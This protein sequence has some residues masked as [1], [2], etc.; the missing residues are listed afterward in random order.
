MKSTSQKLFTGKRF[1][2]C[3]PIMEAINGS[4]VVT[5]EL[6]EYLQSNGADIRVYSCTFGDPVK[7]YCKKKN[8]KVDV[9]A[10]NPK[11]RLTDFDYIWSHSQILPISIIEELGKNLPKKMPKFIFL[12]M[13]GVDWI[14]DE[15]P[16]I[17]NLEK[18]L[19][20]KTLYISE[21]V[22]KTN[23]GFGLENLDSDFFRNPAPSKFKKRNRLPANKPKKILIVSNHPPEEV[24]IARDI[25]KDKHGFEVLTLGESMDD[26]SIVDIDLL[27]KFDA[28]ITIGKTAQYCLT[29][30]TPV[31]IYDWFGGPGWLN[32]DNY[33]RS[34]QKSFSGR[35][36]DK[37][38]AEEIA[39][40]VIKGYSSA[41]S[42]QSKEQSEFQKTLLIDNVLPDIIESIKPRNDLVKFSKEYTK[43][44]V[45][46]EL[47]AK[48]RFEDV[49]YT[50]ALARSVN[51]LEREKE[52]LNKEV[53]SLGKEN[54]LLS[55]KINCR[56]YKLYSKLIAPY[57][58][59]R[60]TI[61]K[62]LQK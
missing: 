14:P 40:E 32:K 55:E 22:A 11:Y 38:T 20:S 4:T 39:S 51:S 59:I 17:F 24:L 27:S 9:A 41:L 16:W 56:T 35:G 19:S 37:K 26:Y 25:I 30:G 12:H 45:F 61:S 15:K 18:K 3:Q 49:S 42:F 54:T 7:S 57:Y 31:Y 62:L 46:A 36:F 50:T 34:L 43:S 58:R 33:N 44:V 28:V 53:E 13:S 10:D 2:I 48:R 29:S 60:R 1:L 8:I 23:L 47:F 5:L 21:G 52:E 6:A